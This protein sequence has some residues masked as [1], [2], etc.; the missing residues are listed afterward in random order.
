LVER[1]AIR[2]AVFKSLFIVET[3]AESFVSIYFGIAKDATIP[4]ITI[5]KIS[6]KSEN[7]DFII[8]LKIILKIICVCFLK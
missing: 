1:R 5:A 2:E 6:S 3:K 7:A 8:I 4:K